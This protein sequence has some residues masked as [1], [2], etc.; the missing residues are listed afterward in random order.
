MTR[1]RGVQYN[2]ALARKNSSLLRGLM[3]IHLKQELRGKAI[4]W[5]DCP[6]DLRESEFERE[7]R[8]ENSRTSYGISTDI[9]RLLAGVR[10]DLDSFSEAEAYAL[11]ASG[12]CMTRGQF[13]GEDKCVE[14]FTDEY[15][16]TWKFTGIMDSLRGQGKGRKHLQKLLEASS[17]R[18]FKIWQQSLPFIIL[19]WIAG[20]VALSLICYGFYRLRETSILPAPGLEWAARN[21]TFGRIGIAILVMLGLMILRLALASLLGKVPAEY[22][23]RALRWRNAL[24]KIVIGTAMCLLGWLAVRVHLHIFDYFYLR[25][26]RLNRFPK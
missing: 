21:L 11:M 20:L 19:K 3:F 6:D 13:E 15:P 2:D 14:G 9:Q 4:A 23:V 25:H 12:Y 22:I 1:V 16:G 17:S 26:G 18:A 7:Q 24:R 10:T 8:A 5:K